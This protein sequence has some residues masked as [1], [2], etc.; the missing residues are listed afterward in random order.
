MA[1]GRFQE[2]NGGTRPTP[3][4]LAAVYI[5]LRYLVLAMQFSPYPETCPIGVVPV[6]SKAPARRGLAKLGTSEGLRQFPQNL[7]ALVSSLSTLFIAPIR[8][9]RSSTPLFRPM[10]YWLNSFENA[11]LMIASSCDFGSSISMAAIRLFIDRFL[12]G[13]K[14]LALPSASSVGPL[15][16]ALA[17]R[18]CDSP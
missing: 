8:R 13:V 7:S 12:V 9:C 17:R 18:G 15:A 2:S 5:A 1:A 10:P 16:L 3:S 14:G 11:A 6:F 4:C